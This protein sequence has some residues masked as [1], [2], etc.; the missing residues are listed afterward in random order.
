MTAL[1][2]E[3]VDRGGPGPS[4]APASLDRVT[5]LVAPALAEAVTRLSPSVA[6]AVDHHLAGGG[7]GVR[8]ALVV[9][10]A[11]GTG[12]P[13]ATGVPGAV[14]IELV[15]NFSLLH[16]DI[17]DGDHERRHRPTVWSKFGVGQAIIA[18]DALAT[19][20]TQVLLD[21][22]TPARVR[23]ASVLAD[24][25]QAMI[26]GQADDMAYESRRWVTVEECLAM[27]RGKTGAL[28][29]CALSLGAVLGG[30]DDAVV[31][32]LAEFGEH[33]GTSFQAVDDVLGIWGEPQVTGK[34]AGSDLLAHKKSLPV[35]LALAASDDREALLELL[36]RDLDAAQVA[37]LAARLEAE[38]ARDET[39]AIADAHLDSALAALARAGL[40][41]GP[42]A[43]LQAVAHYVTARD[44]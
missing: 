40:A 4:G 36:H 39:M 24:A 25:T 2:T 34:P 11:E 19:L 18:G 17:I 1:P 20:A 30:A 8:A 16:D 10:A 23:A 6:E 41:E 21:E 13:S 33:L 37:E 29:A 35:S 31:G 27:E 9:L 22:L 32:A 44:R 43:E 7:K 12:A 42:S 15:H 5:R 26:G 3:Q 14:A 28:L 38:G